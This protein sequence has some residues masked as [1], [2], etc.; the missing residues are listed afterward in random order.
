[1]CQ[2]PQPGMGPALRQPALPSQEGEPK[3]ERL[4]GGQG[5]GRGGGGMITLWVQAVGAE[6]ETE[7]GDL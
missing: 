2:S 1:M 3:T 5:D 4:H 6:G 7:R